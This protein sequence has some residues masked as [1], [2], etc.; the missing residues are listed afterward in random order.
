M[1]E[2]IRVYRQAMP[3]MKPAGKGYADKDGVQWCFERYV[4]PR[5]T[6]PDEQGNVILD[7]CYYVK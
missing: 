1:S 2:I 4:C 6:D 7:M 5:F 3:K